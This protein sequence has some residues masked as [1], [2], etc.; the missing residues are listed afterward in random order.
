MNPA[1]IAQVVS[2]H[3]AEGSRGRLPSGPRNRA[4]S[5]H[6]MEL[7]APCGG[8]NRMGSCFA[9]GFCR[10]THSINETLKGP[11]LTNLNQLIFGIPMV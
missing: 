1:L 2:S 7:V 6:Q 4:H 8:F 3:R 10:G 11:L 9:Q 5:R